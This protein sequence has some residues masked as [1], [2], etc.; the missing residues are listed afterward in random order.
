MRDFASYDIYYV[1]HGESA[2][3]VIMIFEFYQAP[4]LTK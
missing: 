4:I 1:R 2:Q 3:Y